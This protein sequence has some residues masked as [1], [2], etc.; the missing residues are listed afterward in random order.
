MPSYGEEQVSET[1]FRDGSPVITFRKQAFLT[2][3]IV[4]LLAARA[5]LPPGPA[6][7]ARRDADLANGPARWRQ[8]HEAVLERIHR[9]RTDLIFLGDFITQDWERHGPP[10]W[11]DF[12][13]IW[14]RFYGDRNAVNMGFVG[15]TTASLLWRIRNGEVDGISPKVAIVL[16]GAN[17]L[18][19]VHWSASDTVAGIDAIINE[20]RRRLPQTRIL[21]LGVLPSERFRLGKRDHADHQRRPRGA[22]R[23]RERRRLS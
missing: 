9:G 19:R 22:L 12:Q 21:L 13:P 15:D 11:M 5:R 16:I 10:A 4:L 7:R 6:R 3:L 1:G 20:L 17:N 18:G 23:R 14:T 8:R 2:A